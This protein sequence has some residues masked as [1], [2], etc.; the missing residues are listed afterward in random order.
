M[1]ISPPL[2]GITSWAKAA[3]DKKKRNKVRFRIIAL[4]FV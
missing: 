2:A 1:I 4:S 3:K